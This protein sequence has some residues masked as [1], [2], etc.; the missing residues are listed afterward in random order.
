MGGTASLD[1]NPIG[2][3]ETAGH[4]AQQFRRYV[5]A[6]VGEGVLATT[7]AAVSERGAGANM[8]V[9]VAACTGILVEG[10]AVSNQGKYFASWTS[11]VNVTLTAADG[12]NPR[13]DRIVAE[14][15]DD[16]HDSSGQTEVQVR[17]VD[18]TPTSG[19]TLSNLTGAA[20]VPSGSV[21]LANVLVA[22]GDT[23]ISD[24]EIDTTIDTVRP[25]AKTPPQVVAYTATG[26]FDKADYPN[27]TGVRVRVVAGGGGGG[28]AA[29][30]G[31]SEAAV[32]SCGGAGGYAEAW[33]DA[34]SL[35]AS[36][37]VTVGAGGSGGTAGNNNGSTGGASSFGTHAVTA[38]GAG[39]SGMANT[40]GN[41]V[42]TGG[43]GGT[44]SAGDVQI[45]GGDG[46]GSLVVGGLDCAV[47]VGGA[48]YFGGGAACPS[49]DT[50]GEA[51]TAY[52]AGGSGGRNGASTTAVAG[53]DGAGGLVVVEV[54]R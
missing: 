32:G 3:A 31:A 11:A 20:S 46:G 42:R 26:T 54:Y 22:A 6:A 23:A 25:R 28:G 24:A 44:A 35:S 19:A 12:S 16:D 38:G 9:D 29:A 39:G 14:V 27:I 45:E 30:T 40:S 51:G 8:S 15:K 43:A 17:A 7:D 52:G 10:D 47:G 41:N 5:G 49:T 33:I 4:G 36:E 48:S 13:I 18:G 53:G 37:T 1:T 34:G 50:A 2:I 21:L